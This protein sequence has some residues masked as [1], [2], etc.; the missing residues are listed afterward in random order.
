MTV[1]V[2]KNPET[3]TPEREIIPEFSTEDI[4]EVDPA[5]HAYQPE[6]PATPSDSKLVGEMTQDDMLKLMVSAVVQGNRIQGDLNQPKGR[7]F[8]ENRSPLAKGVGFVGDIAHTVVDVA[9]GTL[10]GVVDIVT[11]GQAKGR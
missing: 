7:Q 9:E 4:P 8:D 1:V 2:M 10:R 3:P 11:F 6:A 5:E